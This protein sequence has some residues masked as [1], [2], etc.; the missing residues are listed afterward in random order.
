MDH[1]HLS[2]L[3]NGIWGTDFCLS[4]TLGGLKGGQ[5]FTWKSYNGKNTL[6]GECSG[7]FVM[8]LTGLLYTHKLPFAKKKF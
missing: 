8:G 5:N 2:R 3:Y 1:T 7:S 6:V 4:D